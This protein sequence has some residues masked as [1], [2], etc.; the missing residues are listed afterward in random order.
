MT[1]PQRRSE[2][3]HWLILLTISNACPD[4]MF[5]GLLLDVVKT[6]YQD[7]DEHEL[8]IAICVLSKN[9]LISVDRRYTDRWFCT[10]LNEG[11]RF[12]NYA[13]G[14]IAGI[15]RPEKSQAQELS[16]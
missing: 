7:A 11:L 1:T 6:A 3:I 16:A 8:R 10:M 12:V 13:A 2:T 15:A 14:D 4:G 5:E 9:H